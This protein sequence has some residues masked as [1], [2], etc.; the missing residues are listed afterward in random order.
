MK[1]NLLD[2]L[3][4][5]QTK[6]SRLS[7]SYV[8][9]NDTHGCSSMTPNLERNRLHTSLTHQM[10]KV[11]AITVQKSITLIFC[12][13]TQVT[14]LYIVSPVWLYHSLRRAGDGT[15]LVATVPSGTSQVDRPMRSAV[16]WLI[17][18]A[19]KHRVD[20]SDCVGNGRWHDGTA[21]MERKS[22]GVNGKL[23]CQKTVHI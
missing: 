5:Q 1:E 11:I 14:Q 21:V 23:H 10:V 2:N 9:M 22:V 12:N 13:I 3:I 16:D 8:M 6:L 17:V 19:R 15:T 20:V 4:R 18:L 7:S